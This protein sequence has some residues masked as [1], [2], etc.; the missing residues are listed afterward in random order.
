M[1][2]NERKLLDE[3]GVLILP[4]EITHDTY[5]LV[6][7]ALLIRKDKPMTLYCHGEGGDSCAAGAIVDL[8]RHHS[9]VTGLLVGEANSCHGI[10]FAA[11]FRRYVYPGGIIGIH[12]VARPTLNHVSAEYAMAHYQDLESHDRRN[13][14]IF[15]DACE[16][17]YDGF[18]FWFD[19][20]CANPRALKSLDAS[21][22]IECGMAQPIADLDL[23]GAL[24][25]VED[26]A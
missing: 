25:K 22:L 17:P 3:H 1:T 10:I 12:R 14:Q 21:Y 13:A 9:L 7:E 2:D 11:C 19:M 4:E 6:A 18:G 8:I 26:A 15:A 20:I 5:A 16:S 23:T 24:S